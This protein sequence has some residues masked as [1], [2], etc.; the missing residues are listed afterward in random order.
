M[1]QGAVAQMA[2]VKF[3]LPSLSNDVLCKQ[4]PRKLA[5]QTRKSGALAIMDCHAPSNAAIKV[6]TASGANTPGSI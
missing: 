1:T 6:L 4:F 3:A 5:L 2:L